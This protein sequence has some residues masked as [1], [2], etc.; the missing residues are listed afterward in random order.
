MALYLIQCLHPELFYRFSKSGIPEKPY[1]T[2]DFLVVPIIS[3][4]PSMAIFNSLQFLFIKIFVCIQ[5]I[6]S[7]HFSNVLRTT[8]NQTTKSVGISRARSHDILHSHILLLTKMQ[9]CP[10]AIGDRIGHRIAYVIMCY[11]NYRH[12]SI[13]NSIDRISSSC[14]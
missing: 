6:A 11:T 7:R 9:Y 2:R 1:F 5:I 10:V 14:V 8:I 4:T 13:N 3:P 12:S